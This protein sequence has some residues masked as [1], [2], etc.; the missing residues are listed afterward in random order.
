MG[1]LIEKL[2]NLNEV[3]KNMLRYGILIVLVAFIISNILL[4][5]ANTIRSLNIAQE[6][7]SGNVYALCEILIGAI[8]LDMLIVKEDK[9][10]DQ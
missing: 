6:F 3:S 10:N 2:S 7:T 4:K 5:S 9:K 1:K 8:M